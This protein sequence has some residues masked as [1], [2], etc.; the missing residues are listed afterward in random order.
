VA[1]VLTEVFD[2]GTTGT[3][4][5]TGNVSI[6]TALLGTGTSVFDQIGRHEGSACVRFTSAA[7]LRSLEN[8][9]ASTDTTRYF[10]FYIKPHAAPSANT[11]ILY[12]GAT[13]VSRSFQVV[14]NTDRTVKIQDN[15]GLIIGSNTASACP[16]DLWSRI[17]C[18]LVGSTVTLELYPGDSV[19][20]LPGSAGSGNTRSG[21]TTPPA[22]PLAY[23]ALG[24]VSSTTNDFWLDGFRADNAALPGPLPAVQ[25]DPMQWLEP[26]FVSGPLDW[27]SWIPQPWLQPLWFGDTAVTSSTPLSLSDTAVGARATGP[28]D[29]LTLGI[30]V[31]AG[32]VPSAR[33]GT[34]TQSLALGLTVTDAAA[35]S[36]AGTPTQALTLG[37][38]LTDLCTGSRAGTPTQ[39]FSLPVITPLNLT[40]TAVGARAGDPIQTFD[41]T[42]PRFDTATGARAG[43]PTQLLALGLSLTDH[44]VGSR[45]GAPIQALTLG[46]TV[47]D[48][49]AGARAG[50]PTQT[51]SLPIITPLN[52]SDLTT[53]VRAG[54]PSQAFDATMPRADVAVGSRAGAPT[55]AATFGLTWTDSSRAIRAAAARE[56]AA[57]GLILRDL[58]TGARAGATDPVLTNG[59][60]TTPGQMY[61]RE[62]VGATARAGT[63]TGPGMAPLAATGPQMARKDFTVPT[64]TKGG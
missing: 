12:C 26:G 61:P 4:V 8:S 48:Q 27:D 49:A 47:I 41:A 45:A 14:F 62:L 28:A 18:S 50:A 64:M 53:G 57:F 42:M 13:S 31:D 30:T 21:A 58:A 60:P 6:A 33:A 51:F 38:T 54:T 10:S 24:I 5:T 40:D 9:T 11:P 29:V 2:G 46:L 16:V 7:A 39:T 52:L 43:T 15:A 25:T 37:L 55:Q 36:R 35:G 17:D 63:V 19:D 32:L 34:P 3:A 20:A 22:N 44:A 56:S 59:V 23:Q 1:L